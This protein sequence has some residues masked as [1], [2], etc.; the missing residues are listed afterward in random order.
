MF[1][2]RETSSRE[3]VARDLRRVMHSRVVEPGSAGYD[4]VC[5]TWNGA[6]QSRPAIVAV[7]QTVEDVQAAVRTARAHNL[8][9]SVRGGGHDW[10]GRAICDGGLVI[11]LSEMRQVDIEP[12]AQIATV[13]GG[14]L[15]RDVI[16][17]AAPHGLVAVTEACSHVGMAGLT[18][19]GG[20]GPLSSRYGLALDNLLSVE[21]VLADGRRVIANPRKHSEL[22]W[23]IRGGGGNYGVVTSMRIRLHAHPRLLT[24]M[25]LYPWSEAARVLHGYASLLGWA[26]DTFCA[27]AGLLSGPDGK[28]ALDLTPLWTGEPA[29]GEQMML[30]LQR[31][32]ET[33]LAQLGWMTYGEML[34][35]FDEHI[36]DGRHYAMRTRWLPAL[37]PD[38]IRML[39]AAG[40]ER[41]S[42]L[43]AIV[44]H[45][46]RGAAARVPAYATAFGMRQRHFMVEF[47]AAWRP[48]E[49][50]GVHRQW[51]RDTCQAHEPFSLP[52]GYANLLGPD[53]H[54]Q[55]PHA[56]GENL[57]RL[58]DVKRRFDPGRVFTSAIPLPA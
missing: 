36:V 11:D 47:L 37:T 58:Q 30:R 56:Y 9:L 44:L 45:P 10:A 15:A 41:T 48:E 25:I 1:S 57:A 29:Q 7:C 24:G 49:D 21:I 52:G 14:A 40:Q 12:S 4:R 20:Y 51:L 53:A 26:P 8:P 23:A 22:F 42:A 28:P 2:V 31:L 6:I 33:S 5:R 43:S 38:V 19:G 55:I 18:L 16:A 39:V 32:G 46:F 13:Q 27:Q 3:L 34:A 54:A 50:D 17:A 35:L